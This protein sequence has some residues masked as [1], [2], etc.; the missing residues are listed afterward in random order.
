M[1]VIQHQ[2]KPTLAPFGPF[3]T[4]DEALQWLKEA[5]R[6]WDLRDA[7]WEV[8]Q[9]QEPFNVTNEAA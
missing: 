2:R 8:V 7:R 6:L 3:A 1:F 4:F 9:L 5:R